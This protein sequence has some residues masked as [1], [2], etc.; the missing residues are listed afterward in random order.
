MEAIEGTDNLIERT[1]YLKRK[2]D[3]G[4]LLK[5]AKKNQSG[6]IDIPLIGLETIKK[7]KKFNF[8]GIFLEKNKCLIIN[9][10]QVI[11]YANKNKIFI[12]CVELN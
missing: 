7:I 9:K 4:I 10:D 12:S 3:K 5:F 6:L 11:E 1:S 8:E 2:G